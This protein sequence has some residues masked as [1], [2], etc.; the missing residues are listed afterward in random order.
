[1]KRRIEYYQ[2][3]SEGLKLMVQFEAFIKTMSIE[4]SLRELIKIRASQINGCAYCLSLHT[5]DARRAGET[6]QRL[7]CLSAWREC[8]FYTERERAALALTEAVTLVSQ[9]GVPDALYN[10]VRAQFNEK[11][12]LDLVLLINQINNWN[13]LSIAMGN[14]AEQTASH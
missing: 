10:Q 14:T 1:M 2:L 8:T 9:Q 13:R 5:Q 12:Y 7:Y 11:E 3:G 4:P 6:E